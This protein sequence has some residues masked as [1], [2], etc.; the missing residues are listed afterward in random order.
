MEKRMMDWSEMCEN[1]LGADPTLELPQVRR[2]PPQLA[3]ASL[4]GV[5]LSN[6]FLAGADLRGANLQ[7]AILEGADLDLADLTG[8]VLRHAYQNGALFRRASLT[9]VDLRRANLSYADLSYADLSGADLYG[10]RLSGI[11]PNLLSHELV[12]E[13]LRQAAGVNI[14]KLKLAALV[15]SQKSWCWEDFLALGDPLEDWAL[16]ILRDLDEEGVTRL[17]TI[18]TVPF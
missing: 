12:G 8:A 4:S 9:R 14:E 1:L 7:E 11:Q 3:G 15:R 6:A 10:A 16:G 18:D 17:I 5:Y 2:S 13:I